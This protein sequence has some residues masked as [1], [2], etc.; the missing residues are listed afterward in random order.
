M[1]RASVVNVKAAASLA[2]RAA[3]LE[4]HKSPKVQMRSTSS[5]FRVLCQ[6]HMEAQTD[7]QNKLEQK[8]S[9]YN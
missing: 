9:D 7:F 8:P 2:L 3:L 6:L 5:K 1:V 4:D